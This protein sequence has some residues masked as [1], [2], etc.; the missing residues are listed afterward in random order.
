MTPSRSA[1]LA[2]AAGAAAATV[3]VDIT[4]SKLGE[5]HFSLT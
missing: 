2:G 1:F 3:T 5:L 4:I